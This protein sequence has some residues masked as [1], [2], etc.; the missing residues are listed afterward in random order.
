M[1]NQLSDPRITVRTMSSAE[2]CGAPAAIMRLAALAPLHAEELEALSAATKD[3][4]RIGARRE[5]LSEGEP[6][7]HASI[8]L[9]GWACRTQTLA[10]GRRQI[11]SLML[12]GDLIGMCRHSHPLSSSAVL[13]LTDVTLCPAPQ[14]RSLGGGAGLDEAYALSG[15]LDTA[16]LLRS[17][18][19]LGRMTAYERVADWLLEMHERLT[20]A[21]LAC[22]NQF[23]MPMTQEMLADLLGLTSV[24]M[25]RTLQAMRRDGP[26]IWRSGTVT[27]SDPQQLATL[28]DRR[29]TRVTS[30]E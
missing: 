8:V 14:P 24:H 3:V 30:H 28:V 22:G 11:V 29:P 9:S 5:I 19:R 21:G 4:R 12:P 27:L 26:V 25:N 15:A 7:R 2:P 16:Y 18:T 23:S 6:I 1:P 17:I 10:D 20:L 13:A